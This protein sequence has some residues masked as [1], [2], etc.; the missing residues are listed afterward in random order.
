MKYFKIAVIAIPVVLWDVFYYL[1]T[2]LYDGCTWIDREGGK[3]IEQFM[4]GD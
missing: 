1:V 4:Q 3:V 2:L